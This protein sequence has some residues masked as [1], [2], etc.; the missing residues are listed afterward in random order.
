MK[1]AVGFACAVPP[2]VSLPLQPSLSFDTLPYTSQVIFL[3][4][5]FL[6]TIILLNLLNGLTVKNTDG[7]RKN[8][9]MLSLVARV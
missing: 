2:P 5:V 8:A 3:L 9:E 1:R 7:I 6:V 4:F